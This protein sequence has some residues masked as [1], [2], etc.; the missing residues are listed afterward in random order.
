[1]NTVH[2]FILFSLYGL[3]MGNAPYGTKFK[4]VDKD[5]SLDRLLRKGYDTKEGMFLVDCDNVND[6]YKLKMSIRD[7]EI[8]CER[9]QNPVMEF[10]HHGSTMQIT[11]VLFLCMTAIISGLANNSIFSTLLL[12]IYLL[13]MRIMLFILFELIDRQIYKGFDASDH[14]QFGMFFVW[15]TGQLVNQGTKLPWYISCSLRFIPLMLTFNSSMLTVQ[16]YH[17]EL[18]VIMGL[19]Y[20]IIT[21]VIMELITPKFIWNVKPKMSILLFIMKIMI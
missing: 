11:V 21:I 6:Q 20:A 17:T 18:E 8:M 16:Y 15:A 10:M 1:M 2:I 9:M 5:T 7:F 4:L 12:T 14:V 19:L 13:S 3:Y